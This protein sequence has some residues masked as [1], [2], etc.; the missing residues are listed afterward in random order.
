VALVVFGSDSGI[1]QEHLIPLIDPD[2]KLICIEDLHRWQ[3]VSAYRSGA[4][5]YCHQCQD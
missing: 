4:E 5:K 2:L 3:V 1:D